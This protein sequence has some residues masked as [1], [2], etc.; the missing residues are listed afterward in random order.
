MRVMAHRETLRLGT[1]HRG[2]AGPYF[3]NQDK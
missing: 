2:D 3:A 1:S